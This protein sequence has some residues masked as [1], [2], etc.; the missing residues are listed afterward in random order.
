MYLTRAATAATSRQSAALAPGSTLAMTFMQ[1]LELADRT[2]DL[3][4]FTNE[5]LLLAST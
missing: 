5:A 2:D 3:R 4:P 1:P